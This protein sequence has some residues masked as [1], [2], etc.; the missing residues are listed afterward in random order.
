MHTYS[1]VHKYNTIQLLLG[2]YDLILKE[3]KKSM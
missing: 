1:V 3:K 2:Y